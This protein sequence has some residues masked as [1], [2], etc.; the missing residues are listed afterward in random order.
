VRGSSP[1]SWLP[2][3]LRTL[4]HEAV[5]TEDEP[6]P[7]AGWGAIAARC[8]HRRSRLPCHS[9]A[10]SSGHQRYPADTHGH[11]KAAV[12]LGANSLTCGGGG[13][14]NC[15]ACKGSTLGSTLP[16]PAGRSVP[17][18]GGPE[19]RRR[20]RPDGTGPGPCWVRGALGPQGH[21]RSPAVTSGEENPQLGRPPAQQLARCQR[22]NQIVVPTVEKGV[23]HP[24]SC[25]WAP[26]S[27][28]RPTG[29]Y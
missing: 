7:R 21:E 20:P 27:S 2:R 11:S 8:E 14:R 10:I 9:R 6:H 17:G 1:E 26:M 23:R 5:V 19:R 16:C 22:A 12:G 3:A 28:P 24:R 25:E 15:M 18:R 4:A 13:A 29:L